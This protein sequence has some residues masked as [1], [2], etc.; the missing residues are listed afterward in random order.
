VL[1]R[2]MDL[3]FWSLLGEAVGRSRAGLD[4]WLDAATH[5]M[6]HA[7]FTDPV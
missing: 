2:A 6:Y 7:L 1:A 4:P 5:L 3:F